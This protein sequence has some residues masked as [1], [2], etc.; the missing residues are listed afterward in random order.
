MTAQRDRVLAD[1][2]RDRV[3]DLLRVV[4]LGAVVLGHWLLPVIVTVDGEPFVRLLVHEAE[5]T[6]PATWVFQVMPVFFIVGGWANA[7]A[8]QRAQGRGETAV[9]WA[10]RRARRLLRP[11]V[12][13]VAAWAV[14]VALGQALGIE[15]RWLTLASQSALVPAWFLAVY[16]VVTVAVPVTVRLDARVGLLVPLVLVALVAVAD[17]LTAARLEAAQ[18]TSFVWAWFAIHQ[19][20][21]IWHRRGLPGPLAGLALLVGGL[22]VLLGLVTVLGYPVDMVVEVDGRTNATPPSL[23]M[24]TLAVAWLGVIALIH[25]PAGRLLAR[26]RPWLLVALAG[27]RIMTVFL[28]HL[29]ALVV[30]AAVLVATGVVPVVEPLSGAWWALRPVWILGCALVLA[31]LVAPLGRL[32]GPPRQAPATPPGPVGLTVGAWLAA[33]TIGLLAAEG[34]HDPQGPLGVALLPLVGLLAALA[35]LGVLE[36]DHRNR[37]APSRAGRT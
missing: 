1:T 2:D 28:W 37:D 25:R 3:V 11:L 4:A 31:V 17:A 6:R 29:T 36:P 34:V 35:A 27:S 19:L 8:W 24:P 21:L 15:S 18:W 23:A 30:L 33:G 9:A 12:P 20:G 26:D 14:A 13:L 16:V 7:R 22:V 10:G 32:E 5:W